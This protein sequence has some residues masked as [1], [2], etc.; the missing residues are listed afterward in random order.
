MGLATTLKNYIDAHGT[1]VLYKRKTGQITT[2]NGLKVT[3]TITFRA[4]TV[5]IRE[6]KDSELSGLINAGDR[7]VRIAAE[8]FGGTF[9]PFVGDEIWIFND[10]LERFESFRI[11]SLDSR[12]Y[13][14]EPIGYILKVR[15]DGTQDR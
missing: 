7:E 8:S 2:Q 4:M 11:Y 1:V 10:E 5:Y 14:N 3:P 15:T 9:L 13:K 6:Y 12:T